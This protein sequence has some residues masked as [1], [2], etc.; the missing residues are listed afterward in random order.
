MTLKKKLKKFLK[1]K[2]GYELVKKKPS[3]FNEDIVSLRTNGHAKGNALLAYFTEPF[4]MP[5]DSKVF[6]S[7]AHFD[8]SKIIADTLLNLGYNVDVIDYR[9]TKYFPDKQ[10][11]IL[12]S[13]RT[14]LELYANRL[15]EDCI[16][17]AHL[18]MAHWLFNNPAAYQRCV[19]LLKRRKISL[20][21]ISK[22]Q[23]YNW[24]IETADY[25][26][27]LGNGFTKGT[28]E[29]AGTP[30]YTNNYFSVVEYE[31]PQNKNYD[32]VRKT[33]MWLGSDGLIHKG[34]DLVLEAFTELPEHR[35]IVCG[36]VDKD[37]MFEKEYHVEL[38]E[39]DNITTIGWVDIGST[40]FRRICDSSLGLIYP[41][42][43]E[44]QSGAV[45]TCM[46]AGLIPLVSYES[47]IDVDDFGIILKECSVESIKAEI[48]KL[49]QLKTELLRDMALKSWHTA[50]TSHSRES[51]AK[52]YKEILESI[53][54]I[55]KLQKPI[56]NTKVYT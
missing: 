48:I 49:S 26:V 2:T 38:Y 16:K 6:R 52:R 3:Y 36:P 19:N 24:A 9:N 51:Y 50:R 34:L 32:Q 17:I 44:G 53:L 28:Y 15:N 5:E 30:I 55:N 29:Y 42:A 20:A 33:F 18:E 45:V 31:S 10:Y 46:H 8:E 21:S 56:K 43:S 23:E 47:G 11:T 40:E 1:N 27:V 54:N 41:S 25:A 14:N 13:A 39:T 12:I 7:H 22:L 4:I 37:I 35:L